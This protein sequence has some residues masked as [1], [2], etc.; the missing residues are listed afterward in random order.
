MSS[1]TFNVTAFFFRNALKNS[2]MDENIHTRLMS[3]QGEQVIW[4]HVI[5]CNK[6][7]RRIGWSLTRLTSEAVFLNNFSKMKVKLM[8]MVSI[9]YI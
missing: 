9:V 1:K 5:E 4:D 3:Y 8:E 6:A 2:G 7:D